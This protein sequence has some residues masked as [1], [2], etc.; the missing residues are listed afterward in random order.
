M[1]TAR[2]TATS[3]AAKP[4]TPKTTK[5]KAAEGD[6]VDLKLPPMKQQ[7]F[8]AWIVGDT[9]LITH[10]WSEK[11]RRSML[12]KQQK[13]ATEGKVARDPEGDFRSS[14]YTVE[15]GVYGF[16]AM[17]VKKA[18]LSAAHKDRG[19]PRETVRAALWV[20]GQWVQTRPALGGAVCDMPLLPIYGSEP[21]MREDMVKIG[22]GLN[23]TADLAYRAQF[24]PWAIRITGKLNISM[25]PAAWLPFLIR[26]SGL[27][28]GI[29]DWRNEKGGMFGSF[30]FAKPDEIKEW[31]RYRNGTGPLPDVQPI[32]DDEEDELQEA[33]E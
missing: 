16:P 14:L 12:S 7:K 33:A 30:H 3:V 1:R 32:D 4:A 11:A 15:D 18:I 19:V 24:F 21:A 31:E 20:D 5:S 25:C 8:V 9:P 23:K 27:A 2:K 10:A 6:F 28:T 22:K 26:H 13:T 17:A 29:G